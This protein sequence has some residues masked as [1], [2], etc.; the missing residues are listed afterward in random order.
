MKIREGFVS[1][2]S[3]SSYFFRIN[4]LK[5][6]DFVKLMVSNYWFDHFNK[7]IINHK[8][9]EKIKKAIEDN[10]KH[11]KMYSK[12]GKDSTFKFMQKINNDHILR[13][14]K[15]L[16]DLDKCSTNGQLVKFVLKYKGIKIKLSKEC[17]EFSY[18]T[19]M[20]NDFNEGMEDLLKEIIML[21]S[22]DTNYIVQFE[23]EDS[24]Y[25][26]PRIVKLSEGT[27]EDKLKELKQ[28]IKF[29]K[30]NG[31]FFNKPYKCSALED[32]LNKID[33]D[34][35]PEDNEFLD[36][37]SLRESMKKLYPDAI[38]DVP[39]LPTHMPTGEGKTAK[40]TKGS[41]RKFLREN[42]K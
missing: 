3:S 14:K 40:P 24:E 19:P 4:D 39:N 21:F 20:H 13:C 8:I 31:I 17:V 42:R 2:S 41:F 18:F 38:L 26:M 1:N 12:K 9:K 6:N 28:R 5:F 15:E 32:E 33:A 25:K 10:K 27:E 35:I 29:V 22:F 37:K 16:E 23:R 34:S 36:N 11:S 7:R 30:A